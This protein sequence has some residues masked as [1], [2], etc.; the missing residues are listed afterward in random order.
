MSRGL[1]LQPELGRDYF[2]Y[3]LPP[4]ETLPCVFNQS[5]RSFVFNETAYAEQAA[6]CHQLGETPPCV[7]VGQW[8]YDVHP[9]YLAWILPLLHGHLCQIV[10]AAFPASKVSEHAF[11]NTYYVQ[12]LD[13]SFQESDVL[14]RFFKRLR[15][16]SL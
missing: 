13:D 16:C 6:R 15:F 4:L 1:A 12:L 11:S 10:V 9:A 5:S 14:N 7:F 3:E 2:F 8:H